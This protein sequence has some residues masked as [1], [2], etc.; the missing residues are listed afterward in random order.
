MRQERGGQVRPQTVPP[1]PVSSNMKMM[2]QNRN[3]PADI[4]QQKPIKN[5]HMAPTEYHN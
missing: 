3:S 2:E 5:R 1:S 4:N